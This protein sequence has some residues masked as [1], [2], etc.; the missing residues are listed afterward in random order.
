MMNPFSRIWFMVKS[1]CNLIGYEVLIMISSCFAMW[2]FTCTE[3][4]LQLQSHRAKKRYRRKNKGTLTQ[5]TGKTTNL[6]WY[7]FH[8]ESFGWLVKM[9]R[10][11]IVLQI[12]LNGHRRHQKAYGRKLLMRWKITTASPLAGNY[13]YNY[14]FDVGC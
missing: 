14:D 9:M 6:V 5:C 7:F 10:C 12:V 8:Y 3:F 13:L 11:V 2:N 4:C 1:L